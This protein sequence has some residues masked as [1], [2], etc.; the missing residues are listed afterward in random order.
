VRSGGIVVG[1]LTDHV[2]LR[3]RLKALRQQPCRGQRRVCMCQR[4]LRAFQVGLKGGR[5]DLIQLL[6]GLYFATLGK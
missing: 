6:T 2:R 5:I 4:R 1:L 3:Q